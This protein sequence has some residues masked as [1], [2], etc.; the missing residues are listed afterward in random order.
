MGTATV[1]SG[2]DGTKTV[3]PLTPNFVP[4]AAQPV[5]V[6]HSREAFTAD[7]ADFTDKEFCILHSAFCIQNICVH[8]P[9]PLAP[10]IVLFHSETPDSVALLSSFATFAPFM[11]RQL[12]SP[13][14]RA[15]ALWRRRKP[16]ATAEGSATAD[17]GNSIPNAFP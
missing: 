1:A 9:A 14:C 7:F 5:S 16:L 2:G 11:S 17:C 4:V 15:I 10:S 12:V 13:T 6:A 8:L 3:F